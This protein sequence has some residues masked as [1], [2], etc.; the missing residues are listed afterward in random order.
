[1]TAMV[2]GEKV[3]TP[4]QNSGKQFPR[5]RKKKNGAVARGRN[6]VK[7]GPDKKL[8]WFGGIT[9]CLFVII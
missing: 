7:T 4:G 6:G 2:E 3:Q 8:V 1:M 9:A 5:K